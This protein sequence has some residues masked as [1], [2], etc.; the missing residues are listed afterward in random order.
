M[1]CRS[2]T[3]I[4]STVVAIGS[5][6]ISGCIAMRS[7]EISLSEDCSTNVGLQSVESYAFSS[8]SNLM[9][10]AKNCNVVSKAFRGC[11]HSAFD[12]DD[13]GMTVG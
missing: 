2:L 1:T 12:L 7:V 13:G 3:R 4:F 9:N 6:T 8:C 10:I 5:M 11:Q